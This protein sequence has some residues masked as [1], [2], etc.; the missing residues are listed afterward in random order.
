[1]IAIVLDENEKGNYIISLSNKGKII[2]KIAHCFEEEYA[3]MIASDLAKNSNTK[4]VIN[5]E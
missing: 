4:L 1:M 3:V 2:K 5:I